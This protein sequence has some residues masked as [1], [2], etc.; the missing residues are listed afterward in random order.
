MVID[1][2]YTFE[3]VRRLGI[4]ESVTCRDLDGFFTHVW[5]VHPFASLLTSPGWAPRF[6]GPV[7][8]E[9]SGRH[10]FIEG[11]VGRFG[12]LDWLPP[13]NFAF[14]QIGLFVALY[15]VI[16]RERISVI[17]AGDPFYV[18][19]L[20][21]A[22]ARLGGVPLVVRVGANFD[23]NRGA[24]GQPALPRLFR[25]IA[26]EKWA[27][28]FVLRRADLVAGANQDNLDFALANGARSERST[29]F[30]YG[31]L[32][33][34]GHFTAPRERR[35]DPRRYA[36]LGIRPGQFLLTVARLEANSIKHPDD[37]V[38]VLAV[39]RAKGHDVK[40]V[41]AGEGPLR[42]ELV[43]LAGKLGVADSLVLAGPRNQEWLA[44][45]YANAAVF[46]SPHAGRA[47]SEAAL[48]AAPVVGYDLD[49]QRELIETDVTGILVPNRDVDGLARGV[50]KFLGDR[51]LARAMGE[52]L[53]RR[54]LDMLDPAALD[55]HE[56]EEYAKLFAR[57]GPRGSAGG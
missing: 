27:E 40:A 2:S 51:D 39:V 12:W 36:E 21:L 49:W 9:V 16:R 33:D 17:R 18:G 37:V 22:L 11:K 30:R 43:R 42:D 34:R 29:L 24:S 53:R 45:M 32:I 6:G 56:R 35:S 57:A 4:E 55:A 19:L 8:H 44:D 7:Q 28:R 1:T 13:L 20:G 10:S 26:A 46:L 25:S 15:R 3:A 48:A 54:A 50:E 14:A 41:I 5:T 31:N 52:A 47:L 38:R 23:V